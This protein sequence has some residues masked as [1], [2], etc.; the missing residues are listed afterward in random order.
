MQLRR[1]TSTLVL[2]IVGPCVRAADTNMTESRP[3]PVFSWCAAM[4][5]AS[6]AVMPRG[7]A[8]LGADGAMQL[9]QGAFTAEAANDALLAACKASNELSIEII[10]RTDSLRQ[11]G[12]ARIITFSRDPSNRNFT[13]GQDGDRLI[14][15]LRTPPTGPNGVKPQLTLCRAPSTEAQHIV[16]TYQSGVTTCYVNGTGILSSQR[17]KG[18][19]S[20]WE[21]CHLLFGDEW[22]GERD[23]AGTLYAVTVYARALTPEQ[24]AGNFSACRADM[25]ELALTQQSSGKGDRS[26]TQTSRTAI[27]KPAED[28]DR[29]RPWVENPSYW[30]YRGR[31]LLLLGASKDDNLFQI[32]DLEAHLDEM[33]SAGA[34]YIRNTMSDRKDYGF[35]VYACKQLPDGKY[36]L[37]QWNDEYWTRFA[38]LLRWTHERE[39]IVQIEVWDR[40]DYSRDNWTPHPYNPKNNVNYSHEQSGLAPSYPDHPGRNKQPFFF[41]TPKQRNNTVVLRFQQRVVDKMLSYALKYD[42]VLYCMD[43]ET[44]GEE[45][46]GAYWADYI[47]QRATQAGRRVCVTEMW[48]DWDL[49]ADR[50]RRTL[51]HPERYDFA[52]VSQN[53]QKK[54]QEHWDNFQWVRQHVADQPR[55]LNTVKTYGAD[56]GRFGDNR[57]GI[58]RWWRHVIGGAAS[59]RFHRP[60]SGLGLSEPAAASVQ[61]ARKLESLLKLWNVEPADELLED[62]AENEAYLAARP[63]EA[64]ALYFPNGGSVRLDLTAASGQLDLRWIDIGTGAWHG[65]STTINGG[66]TVAISAP[67]KGH[68][69][70]ALVNRS[71]R[72]D[73]DARINGPLRRHPTNPRYFTDDSGRAILLTGSHTWN[74]L[75]DIGPTDPPSA[76]DFDKYLDWMAG[77]GHNFMRLW[78]WEL[79]SWDT[80]GNQE[81]EAMHHHAAPQPWARTGPGKAL[82]GKPKFDLTTLND[83]YFARLRQRVSAACDRD[84]YT[85]V[86]L[87]EGWGIQFSPGGWAHH[88]L[89]AANNVN[90]INGDL[91]GNGVGLEVHSGRSAEITALQRAYVRKV[92]DTVNSFDNVLYEISNENHPGSTAWQYDM[93]RFIRDCEKTKPKQHPVGMTF[94]YKGGSNQTLFDSPADWISPNP[95]G[96]YN[97]KPP[98]ADGAKVI[99]NDTDHLW[100]I[101]GNAAWVWESVLR[102]MNPI[103]MDPYDGAVLKMGSGADW[104]EAI[105]RAM[106]CVLDMSRRIDLAAMMPHG[107]LASSAYCLANHGFEYLVYCPEGSKAVSVSLPPGSFTAAWI[108]PETGVQ[109]TRK[110]FQHDG[111]KRA[112]DSPSKDDALLHLLRTP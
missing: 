37:E 26:M 60:T 111:G 95:T 62:R 32:P 86:M 84:I 101:G 50:H 74:S 6:H 108:E 99:V 106:G 98:A 13:L 100:G 105:R 52:D 5:Q 58:E 56:G 28:D 3:V 55:P 89:N 87:F 23:W 34:N 102:G 67:G 57:D 4:S 30:Q 14:L 51:D 47:R 11:S 40:F 18:D 53:N 46:W 71:A 20:N 59:A 70:A 35:E 63:G 8:R 33:K 93:I 31:P 25:K 48:D 81:T 41:T 16:V 1:I 72:K 109:T 45:A 15:R 76:F 75:V 22:S 49:K 27:G 43:N 65:D 79:T 82:D 85:A 2:V 44:A 104:A 91:D 17:V 78:T 66:G 54:G 90:S 36:D 21:P 7:Q 80:R 94:Q 110:P 112:F 103:F 12:P 10:V 73:T 38:N 19:F 92:I 96:G 64:Y 61:A 24:V 42:H 97:D 29:I 83:E 69:V 9:A 77:Y 68:W 88:P 39:I 107:D